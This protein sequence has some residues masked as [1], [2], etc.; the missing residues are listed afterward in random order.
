[1]A[2]PITIPRLGWSMEEGIFVGWLKKDGE[3]I[4]PG[5]TLYALESEKSTEEIEAIDAG[6]LR[7]PSDGPKNGATVKVG[8]VLGFLTA[9]G[10]ALPSLERRIS[11][12]SQSWVGNK[13]DFQSTKSHS[14]KATQGSDAISPRA[15][16]LASELK[17]DWSMLRGS[18]RGGRI[19][20][21]D[22]RAAATTRPTGRW[23]PHTSLRRT[24]AARMVAGVTQAA[25]VTLFSKFDATELV[26]FRRLLKGSRTSPEK[27]VPSYT[28]IHLKLTAAA[29]VQHPHL[30]AQWSDQALFIPEQID[31][32]FAVD[33][34]AGLLAPVVRNAD[35]LKLSEIT[36]RTRDLIALARDGRLNAADMRDAVFTVSNLGDLGIDAFTP[37]IHLPQCAVLGIGRIVRE[38]VVV[39]DCIVPRDMM[40]L[41]LTFDH[42]IVDGAPAA[43]FLASIIRGAQSCATLRSL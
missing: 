17:I 16:R 23:I 21:R 14:D 33:T 29:L 2:I 19:R 30:R 7:I 38:A 18:G 32:A 39:E 9:E 37:I 34:D 12:S 20:E 42:R 36:A 28:D 26:N 13:A 6:I 22:I 5:D 35:K 4:K 11:K 43:R 8:D 3:R 31:V 10:E 41:S 24:I 40:T 27:H 25:S 1:M 15:R